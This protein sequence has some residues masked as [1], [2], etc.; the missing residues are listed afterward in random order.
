MCSHILQCLSQSL[1]FLRKK[2]TVNK[3]IKHK[4]IA[5]CKSDLCLRKILNNVGIK[6][7]LGSRNFDFQKGQNLPVD[8]TSLNYTINYS[9]WFDNKNLNYRQILYNSMGDR[10]LIMKKN[11]HLF[12]INLQPIL[13]LEFCQNPSKTGLHGTEA[14]SFN[15][16][17]KKI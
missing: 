12:L 7:S 2:Y 8:V 11:V 5:L 15:N 1:L 6:V 3:W 10:F 4:R 9:L 13:L 17:F 16:P 14:V